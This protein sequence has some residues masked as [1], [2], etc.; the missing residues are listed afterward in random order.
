M[1]LD[2]HLGQIMP[3]LQVRRCGGRYD[4]YWFTERLLCDGVAAPE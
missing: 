1:V 3:M 4:G 2:T